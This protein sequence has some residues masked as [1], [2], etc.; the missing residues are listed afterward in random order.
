[1][2]GPRLTVQQ[3]YKG[4]Q[5]PTSW[6]LSGERIR[7]AA[8]VIIGTEVAKEIPYFRAHEEAVQI[9]LSI[10]CTGSN[11]SGQAEIK[12]DPP[13]YP[14]AQL[15][16]AYAME[17]L[18]KGLIVANNPAVVDENKI[19]SQLKSHDLIQL[20]A[21]AGVTVHVEEEPVLAAL[22]E[23]SV[24]AARY[25]VATRK[26][27]Y[28]GRENPHAMLDYGSRHVIMRRFFDRI[29]AE[30]TAKLSRAPSRYDVVVVFRQPGT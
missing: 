12:C 30:L 9:A 28:V 26:E 27:D 8:E 15:L 10:A 1:M 23:L 20:S 14:P 5:T 22:S 4:A 29:H 25:P 19:S 7:D 11:K 13:N 24:W 6:L 21:S 16:Y 2:S 17:N 18:L 3:I